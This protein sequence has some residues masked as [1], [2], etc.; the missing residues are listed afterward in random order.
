MQRKLD[1]PIVDMII[2]ES[3][4]VPVKAVSKSGN[5]VVITNATYQL[6]KG[7]TVVASGNC[8]VT[9]GCV[10]TCQITPTA[11]GDYML[12]VQ[13][14]IAPDT[15]KCLVRVRVSDAN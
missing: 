5:T 7:E 13:G 8:T 12:V 1:L 9:G 2:G 11:V 15:F 14:T 4:T 10:A 6:K 3:R